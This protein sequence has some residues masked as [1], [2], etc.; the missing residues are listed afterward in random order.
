[1]SHNETS[2]GFDL[3]TPLGALFGSNAS[4]ILVPQTIIGPYYVEG[5]VIRK[6]ITDKEQGV[7]THLDFQFIDINT[8]EA[9]PNL[10][11]DVWHANSTGVYSGVTAEGQGGLT[12]NFGRGIQQT[13]QDGVVQF[14]T[15]FPG[16][17]INRTNHI[18][19]MSTDNATMLSNGTFEGGTVSHIGQTYFD[20]VLIEAVETNAPYTQNEQPLTR[21]DEDELTGDHATEDYDPFMKYVYLGDAAGDGLLPWITVGIDK[22]ANYNRNV[23]VASH[24][25]PNGGTDEGDRPK[26]EDAGWLSQTG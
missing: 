5:E 8:C 12:T 25:H 2:K 17:Y 21:N 3:S 11:I 7:A 9:V 1:L 18:H 26:A 4:C 22:T 23:S 10:V 14:N 15:I 6:D 13:D 20:Q 24:W 19:V 16:H